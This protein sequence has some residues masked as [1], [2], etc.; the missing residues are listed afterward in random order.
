MKSK[1][2]LV[3]I[4]FLLVIGIFSVA[5]PYAAYSTTT[6]SCSATLDGAQEVP[7]V[8][9]EG[10]GSATMEF[11]PS[12][13]ELSWSI[14]FSELSGPATAAHFHGPATI[15]ANAGVQ[16]NI[17][18]VSGLDSPMEGSIELT[19]EQASMLLDGELYINIHTGAN[20]N[21]EIRGQVTCESAPDGGST[22]TATVVIGDEEFEIQYTISGGTLEELTADSSTQTLMASISSTSDGNLTIWLPTEVIDAD[23]D[24]SVFIDDE[25]GNFI[26]DEL[27]PTP[28]A[29]VLQIEFEQGAQEIEIVGTSMV[30]GEE[31][32]QETISVEIEGQTYDIPFEV[33]GGTL[34]SVD[35]DVES[36]SLLFTI[37]SN[38]SGALTVW[39]PTEVID[40]DNDFSVFID[41]A[42]ANFTEMAPSANARILEIEFD[43]GAEEIEIMGTTIVPEF[44]SL[45]LIVASISIVGVIIASKRFHRFG[46]LRT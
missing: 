5:N 2:V 27:E 17:G 37:S 18:E 29:R 28:D 32:E 14:E 25:F 6:T 36:K 3:P 1:I 33:K 31:P 15:G 40:A 23:N 19:A 9:T 26:V 45:A 13:S 35:A 11:D 10:S 22:E 41:G 44:G 43:E 24:F 39:L 16:V 46:G 30:G 38:T 34:Q 20:P 21:G 8:D 42:S 7:A 12:N 4:S